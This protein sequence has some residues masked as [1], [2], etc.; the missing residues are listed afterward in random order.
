MNLE[1]SNKAEDRESDYPFS[2]KEE[3]PITMKGINKLSRVNLEEASKL[4]S[5]SKPD[6]ELRGD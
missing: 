3:L 4:Y 6:Y 5:E 1:E 2:I